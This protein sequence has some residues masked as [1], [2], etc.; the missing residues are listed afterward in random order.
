MK[1]HLNVAVVVGKSFFERQVV[2]MFTK[3]QYSPQRQQS[4]LQIFTFV[5]NV[6]PIN[7]LFL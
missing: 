1:F 7:F 2:F 3:Y 6:Q 4:L 5:V